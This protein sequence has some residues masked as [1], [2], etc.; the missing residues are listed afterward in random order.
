MKSVDNG[1]SLVFD[2]TDLII[3]KINDEHSIVT[4]KEVIQHLFFRYLFANPWGSLHRNEAGRF[5]RRHQ[6]VNY[7]LQLMELLSKEAACNA[8]YYL[9]TSFKLILSYFES[10]HRRVAGLVGFTNE[11]AVEHI[12]D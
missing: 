7:I 10:H 11:T 3:A 2:S 9:P 12:N 5:E 4:D 1:G 6:T 8:R